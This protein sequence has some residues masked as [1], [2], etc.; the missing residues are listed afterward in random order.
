MRL[1]YANVIRQNAGWGA[2]WFVDRALRNA[3]HETY[4]VDYRAQRGHIGRAILAAPQFDG[5]LLQRGDGFPLSVIRA[6]RTPRL[7]WASELVARR[8]DQ[9]RLF[10]SGLFEHVFVRT[11]DCARKIA[12]NGWVDPSH[13][14]VLLSGFDPGL[15]RPMETDRDLDVLFVGGLT[16]RRKRI[17]ERLGQKFRLTIAS[18]FGE[19]MVQLVNRAKIVLNIHAE[20]FLDTETRVYEVL[21]CRRMLISE[22][23]SE[24]N[25]FRE[26]EL[27]EASAETELCDKI[28]Y[29]LEHSVEREAIADRGYRSALNGHTYGHRAEQ[30]IATM[31]AVPK[32]S[33]TS[34]ASIV[35]TLGLR[36][37][38]ATEP[39]LH[40]ISEF[41]SA[42]KR[43]VLSAFRF[44]RRALRRRSGVST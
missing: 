9:D 10:R 31:R 32:G 28:Q 8:R 43:P 24:E 42:A 19:E 7:F 17:L 6:I 15:H 40:R 36:T 41:Y 34:S 2:E 35:P 26:G 39:L 25:P 13:S 20:N 21:G 44:L 14:S 11:P 18:K 16:D 4:C 30:I 27:V 37:F 22:P 12:A 5:F 33:R 23:L 1:L 3:G 38:A 29:Y